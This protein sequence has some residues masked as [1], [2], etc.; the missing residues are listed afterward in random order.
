V[1]EALVV[2]VDGHRQ[3]ALGPLL[4]D[5]IIIE[6][7]ADFLRRRHF[8]I[9]ASGRGALGFLADDVVAQLDTFIADEYC[10][11]GNQ[12]ADFM[13]GFAAEGAI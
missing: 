10:G 3:D 1:V 7:I 9:L 11:S 5:D 8:A 2:I 13:L 4:A 6:D 12:L